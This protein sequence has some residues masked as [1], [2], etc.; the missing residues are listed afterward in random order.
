MKSSSDEF[1]ISVGGWLKSDDGFCS[2]CA[3]PLKVPFKRLEVGGDQRVSGLVNE[4]RL[5]M[6]EA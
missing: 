3:C 1:M 5:M 4:L 2:E 6:R